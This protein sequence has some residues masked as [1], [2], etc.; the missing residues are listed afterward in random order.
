[1]LNKQGSKSSNHILVFVSCHF[2]GNEPQVQNVML[3]GC[4]WW[5]SILACSACRKTMVE[6]EWKKV[7]AMHLKLNAGVKSLSQ[8]RN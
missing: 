1:M 8:K 6:D 3:V 2:D 5:I 4:D 7:A